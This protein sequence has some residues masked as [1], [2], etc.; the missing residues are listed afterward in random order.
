MAIPSLILDAVSGHLHQLERRMSGKEYSRERKLLVFQWENKSKTFGILEAGHLCMWWNI[1]RNVEAMNRENIFSR[2]NLD[3][4][5]VCIVSLLKASQWLLIAD[6]MSLFRGPGRVFAVT[7]NTVSYFLPSYLRLCRIRTLLP[8]QLPPLHIFSSTL[9]RQEPSFSSLNLLK[10][11]SC[12]WTCCSFCLGASSPLIFAEWIL[13]YYSDL[14][15]HIISS[16][17]SL[18]IQ[19]TGAPLSSSLLSSQTTTP[20]LSLLFYLIF[21]MAH[22]AIV[23]YFIIIVNCNFFLKL[24]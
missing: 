8:L 14:S 6:R 24:L 5:R 9:R 13:S 12:L 15:S 2:N 17:I 3:N 11:S 21:L 18:A 23:N 10:Q 7:D 1:L 20:N 22:F 4:K 16:E 19:S